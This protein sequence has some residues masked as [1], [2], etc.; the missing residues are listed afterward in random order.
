MGFTE[1]RIA[2][3]ALL[4]MKAAVHAAKRVNDAFAGVRNFRTDILCG[5]WYFG[6]VPYHIPNSIGPN[7]DAEQRQDG[8]R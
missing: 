4:N 5:P 1:A 2:T 7:D 8:G 6:K 3:A